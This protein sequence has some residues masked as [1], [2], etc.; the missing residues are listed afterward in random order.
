MLHL[1]DEVVVLRE[2]HLIDESLVAHILIADVGGGYALALVGEDLEVAAVFFGCPI[3]DGHEVG[4]ER[5]VEDDGF[6]VPL[7]D[8]TAIVSHDVAALLAYLQLVGKRAYAVGGA[9][10]CQDDAHSIAL[11]A[12]QGFAGLGCYLFLIV[13]QCSVEI[14]HDCFVS[15]LLG[16]VIRLCYE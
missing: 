4:V 7:G 14:E 16:V 12:Q 3:Q 6:A 8:A 9:S 2:R 11:G 13:G 10:R 15:H 1:M 5:L